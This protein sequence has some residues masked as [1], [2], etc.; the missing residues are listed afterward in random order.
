M[1]FL[2]APPGFTLG[3]VGFAAGEKSFIAIGGPNGRA[4]QRIDAPAPKDAKKPGGS[5]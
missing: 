5:D 3:L 4:L 2:T 1:K